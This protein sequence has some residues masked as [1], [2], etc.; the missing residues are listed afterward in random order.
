MRCKCGFE[1]AADARFCGNCRLALGDA[2]GNAAPPPF[3]ATGV[4]R[5]AA[6]PLS[7]KGMVIVAAA[8]VVAA[9]GYWWFN[10]PPGLYKADNGGLY[11][12]NI[13]GKYGFMDRSGKTV[14]TPQFD[15]AYGF[16]EG[17]AHVRV[18]NKS[19]YI[20]PKGVSVITPQFDDAMQFQYGRAAVKQCCG[21]WAEQNGSNRF[22]FIEK[23]G[24]YI[25]SPEFHCVGTGFSGDLVSVQTADGAL[26][27]MNRS[28]KVVLSVKTESLRAIGFAAGLAPT[29]SGGKWGILI[30]LVNGSL[31]HSSKTL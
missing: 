27:F 3:V 31:I 20:N 19:G 8:V 18:G 14:I 5:A 16:S 28:G 15:L 26:A 6:R 23:D 11:P 12:I 29:A 30:A 10:R 24:K 25:S 7:R 22:G 9:A 4:G 17:L 21:L 2:P 1:N 13:N